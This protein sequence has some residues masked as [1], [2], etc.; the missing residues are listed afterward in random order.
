MTDTPETQKST[1]A[2][3]TESQAFALLQK[4][5][6]AVLAI[7]IVFVMVI[8][9]YMYRQARGL[10]AEVAGLQKMEADFQS[11]TVPLV[12]KFLG[13]LME[14]AKTHPD[15]QAILAKYPIQATQAPGAATPATA[16]PAKATPAPAKTPTPTA[17]KK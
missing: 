16:V 10:K 6:V 7:L 13:Q 8:D 14:F 3:E 4:Q 5:F 15:F 11:V 17:P 1:A 9:L 12:N 2:P